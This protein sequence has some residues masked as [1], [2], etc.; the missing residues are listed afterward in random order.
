M[1]G[2]MRPYKDFVQKR[3]WKSVDYDKKYDYQCTDLAKQYIDEV[4]D[5]KKTGIK[6]IWPLWNAKDMPNNPFFSSWEKIKGM[7][8]LMQ[9]DII[10][11]SHGQYGHVAIVDHVLNGK[12]YVLEQNGSGKNSGSGIWANAIRIQPY[13]LDFYDTIL[14]CKKIFDNLVLEREFAN[15][16]IEK[17]SK[18]WGQEAEIRNTREYL[19]TTRYIVE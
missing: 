9:G 11:S 3:L 19:A 16:K 13:R 5:I 6:K 8:N 2:K 12:V 18:E 4:L 17:L 10:I 1:L 7:K 14:R 15:A